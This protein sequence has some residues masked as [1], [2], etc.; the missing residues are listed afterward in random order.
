[1]RFTL[2]DIFDFLIRNTDKFADFENE[3]LKDYKKYKNILLAFRNF[4]GLE[5]Y[6]LKEVDKYLWQVGKKYYPRKYKKRA[7]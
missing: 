3:D 1:M 5:K 7:R 6:S 4:Y 2:T